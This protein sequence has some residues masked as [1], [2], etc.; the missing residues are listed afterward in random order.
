MET[1]IYVLSLFILLQSVLKISFWNKWQIIIYGILCSV[2]VITV[3]PYAI[4]QSQTTM[5]A[6]L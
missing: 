4:E 1:L 3:Y 6:H 2:F 5:K